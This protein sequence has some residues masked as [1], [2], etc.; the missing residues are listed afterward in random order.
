M[1]VKN[2]YSAPV[3][4]TELMIWLNPGEVKD[5]PLFIANRYRKVLIPMG[6]PTQKE[7]LDHQRQGALT[8]HQQAENI[9]LKKDDIIRKV[10]GQVD[11][12]LQA[13][14]KTIVNADNIDLLVEESE[15]PLKVEED[16]IVPTAD[17]VTELPKE[18]IEQSIVEDIALPEEVDTNSI[19]DEQDFLK[20]VS[21]TQEQIDFVS[22][23][24]TRG[25]KRLASELE[26]TED[27]IAEIRNL[28]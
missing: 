1:L 4:I 15:T 16:V 20:V 2:N 19:V 21:Y 8:A 10:K 28:I 7:V 26:L 24:K 9:K 3:Q 6:P 11:P 14:N 25:N 13:Q 23:N 27:D 17:M 12:L 5:I 22:K 18:I